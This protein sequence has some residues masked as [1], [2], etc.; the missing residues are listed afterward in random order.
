MKSQLTTFKMKHV[1]EYMMSEK[2]IERSDIY[3]DFWLSLANLNFQQKHI[4]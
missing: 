4:Y 3:I 2:D 1:F